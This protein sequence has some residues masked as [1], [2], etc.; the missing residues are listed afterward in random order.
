M[1]GDD[2]LQTMAR[3]IL[4]MVETG[5]KPS[6]E[7]LVMVWQVIKEAGEKKKKAGMRSE[8]DMAND[9]D[10]G[11]EEEA[12]K[13]GENDV[14]VGV[15][16][17][18]LSSQIPGFDEIVCKKPCVLYYQTYTVASGR[19]D[20]ARRVEVEG[21]A[22]RV[23]WREVEATELHLE[24]YGILIV[25]CSDNWLLQD[26]VGSIV[27]WPE[28]FITADISGELHEAIMAEIRTTTSTPKVTYSTASS[29]K[30]QE[31]GVVGTPNVGVP[32]K[33]NR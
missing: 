33:A 28:K 13:A 6:E 26:A 5:D 19:I 17:T 3:L 7:E 4:R 30:I 14:E 23:G 25:P 18:F 9:Q 22:P 1:S 11:D 16:D 12:M 24:K 20:V 15:E 8:K 27:Q 31:I 10:G 32:L 29:P 2:R 21:I